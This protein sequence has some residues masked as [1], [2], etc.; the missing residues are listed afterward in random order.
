MEIIYSFISLVAQIKWKIGQLNIKLAFLND[1][2][3]ENV[4]VKQPLSF[5]IKG[6]ED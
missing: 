4:Y 3:E 5:M 2:L 1:Y 6:H